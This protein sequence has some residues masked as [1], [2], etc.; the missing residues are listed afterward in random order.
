MFGELRIT[1][2]CV[3][4]HFDSQSVFHLPNHQVYH[5]ITNHTEIH[6]Y[7]I[8]DM[9]EKIASDGRCVHQVITYIIV[10]NHQKIKKKVGKLKG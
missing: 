5:E 7:L 1:Q 10:W 4:I 6:L 3:K 8:R 2:R 9:I